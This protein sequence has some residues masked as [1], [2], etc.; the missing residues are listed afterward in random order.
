MI[1]ERRSEKTALAFR[2]PGRGDI[3]RSFCLWAIGQVA[4]VFTGFACVAILSII[5]PRNCLDSPIRIAV[6]TSACG[7]IGGM[8][9]F[10]AAI[11]LAVAKRLLF[12]IPIALGACIGLCVVFKV[13]LSSAGEDSPVGKLFTLVTAV[14][15]FCRLVIGWKAG[16]RL[17]GS[18]GDAQG[19][20][21][22]KLSAGKILAAAVRA[23]AGTAALM[24]GVLMVVLVRLP[25][26][27]VFEIDV[28]GVVL[29]TILGFV[30]GC[31]TSLGDQ[32]CEPSSPRDSPMRP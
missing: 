20:M 13:I 22:R 18:G 12:S 16:R 17:S 31:T 27:D 7:L 11:A 29:Y 6:F 3:K 30:L 28:W 2:F 19:V 26:A 5:S 14:M 21:P 9:S 4:G 32:L 25:V 1:L 8:A 10:S 23:G 24:L 15:T